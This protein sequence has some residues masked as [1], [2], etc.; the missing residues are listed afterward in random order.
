MKKLLNYIGQLRIYSLFDLILLLA[1]IGSQPAQLVGGVL[2]HIGFLAYLEHSHNHPGRAKVPLWLG[3]ILSFL[4]LIL[5]GRIEAIMYILFGWLY[6][7]KIR[8]LGFISPIFRG[9][10]LL[11][12]VG[13]I[14][15]YTS[16]ITYVVAAVMAVRNLLGDYRDVTKDKAHGLRTIPIILGAKKSIPG[17]H[18]IAVL[19][20]SYIWWSLGSI[21]S[22]WLMAGIVIELATYNLRP[23]K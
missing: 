18:L 17:I 10:Q 13:G 3:H 21:S 20:S 19:L 22:A 5:F 11:F 14:I 16:Y 7:Q 15:G 12:L 8:G 4:G 9:L 2:L 1:V 6:I 23:R